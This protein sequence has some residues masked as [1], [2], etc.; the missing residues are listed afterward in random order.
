MTVFATDPTTRLNQLRSGLEAAGFVVLDAHSAGDRTE[1]AVG[2]AGQPFW[3]HVSQS[4]EWREGHSDPVN[5]Y[6]ARTISPLLRADGSEE[7]IFVFDDDA[8]NFV[9]LWPQTFS[10]LAQSDLGLMIHPDYGLWL[11]ARA[12][13]IL[14]QATPGIDSGESFDPCNTCADKPCLS[15]CPIE[16]FPAPQ[17]FDYRAC[18]AHLMSKPACFSGGCD[19]RAACPYGQSWQL[20]KDQAEYHQNRFRTAVMAG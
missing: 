11:A 17:T 8:P 9:E 10:R 7:V 14:H 2:S 4:Q 6:T 12:H 3:D 20:P 15:A 16:A 5:A 13:I 1:V 19:A 18:A